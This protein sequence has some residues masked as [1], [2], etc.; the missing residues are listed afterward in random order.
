MP[1]GHRDRGELTLHTAGINPHHGT[2]RSARGALGDA[3]G[4]LAGYDGL[5]ELVYVPF[6]PG[7]ANHRQED[8]VD[9][10]VSYLE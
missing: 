2:D 10:A 3:V 6:R 1:V 9:A 4:L 5:V 7:L 8:G